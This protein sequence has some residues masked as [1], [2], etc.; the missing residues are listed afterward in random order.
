MVAAPA[1][2]Q[3]DRPRQRSAV[4]GAEL[5]GEGVDVGEAVFGAVMAMVYNG[6]LLQARAECS[7]VP[8]RLLGSEIGWVNPTAVR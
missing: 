3:R 7:V 8:D 4:A 2:D 1:L 6:R 5:L